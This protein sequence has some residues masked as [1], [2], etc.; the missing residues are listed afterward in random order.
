MDLRC[1]DDASYVIGALTPAD[2]REFQRHLAQ[3]AR[4]QASVRQLTQVQRLLAVTDAHA[5]EFPR[6]S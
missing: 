1:L 3:C 5:D 2:R 4:C 6:R